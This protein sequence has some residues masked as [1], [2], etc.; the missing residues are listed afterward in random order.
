VRNSTVRLAP[1]QTPESLAPAAGCRSLELSADTPLLKAAIDAAASAAKPLS[2]LL[3][4]K[5][6]W[7]EVP[8]AQPTPA[9]PSKSPSKP[10]PVSVAAS[11]DNYDGVF[12]ARASVQSIPGGMAIPASSGHTT[13]TAVARAEHQRTDPSPGQRSSG[14]PTPPP[15]KPPPRAAVE[16]SDDDDDLVEEDIVDDE[17][18]FF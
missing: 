10:P 14:M 4:P 17:D 2:S 12:M 9:S 7:G 11:T 6:G 13:P 8:A 16:V 15:Q 18:D 1:S 5:A 3:Q